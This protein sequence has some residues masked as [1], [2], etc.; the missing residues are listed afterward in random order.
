MGPFQARPACGDSRNVYDARHGT[1]RR[2]LVS[3]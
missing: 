1:N 2:T 3:I